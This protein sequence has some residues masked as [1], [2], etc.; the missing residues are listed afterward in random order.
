[1]I[2]VCF[3]RSQGAGTGGVIE[4][5]V[6]S[7]LNL[8]FVKHKE[9]QLVVRMVA[10]EWLGVCEMLMKGVFPCLLSA[11]LSSGLLTMQVSFIKMRDIIDTITTPLSA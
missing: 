7:K 5:S 11:L 4:C 2:S 8:W 1:M 9:W 10:L 3:E 6:C